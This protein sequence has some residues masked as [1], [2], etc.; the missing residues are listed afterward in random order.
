MIMSPES[1]TR[2]VYCSQEMWF[3]RKF[4]EWSGFFFVTRGVFISN[5]NGL[6]DKNTAT[7]TIVSTV[8]LLSH[9]LL[10]FHHILDR[11]SRS[12]TWWFTTLGFFIVWV[13]VSVVWDGLCLSLLNVC[14]HR[15]TPNYCPG[16]ICHVPTQQ[17]Y[18][19][20]SIWEQLPQLV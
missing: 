2:S 4:I 1:G 10:F 6:V 18:T 14:T 20:I 15:S 7:C 8:T 12:S 16:L 3:N 17:G 13:R 5:E 19:H 11:K 9:V